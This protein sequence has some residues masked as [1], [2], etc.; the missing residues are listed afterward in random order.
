MAVAE[1]GVH[2]QEVAATSG[3]ESRYHFHASKIHPTM[4]QSCSATFQHNPSLSRIQGGL[5]M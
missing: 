1:L 2:P 5:Q 3:C 4:I